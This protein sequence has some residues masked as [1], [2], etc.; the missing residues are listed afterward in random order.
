[1]EDVPDKKRRLRR[2]A[3]TAAQRALDL[4]E[5]QADPGAAD[6]A[7][8]A[9]LMATLRRNPDDPAGAETLSRRA[10]SLT[11]DL[12]GGDEALD[13][14]RLH[15][16]WGLAQALR[17]RGCHHEAA[18]RLHAALMLACRARGVDDAETTAIEEELRDLY[19]Y[20]GRF[21]EADEVAPPTPERGAPSPSLETAKSASIEGAGN[22]VKPS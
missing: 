16:L 11:E 4:L 10:L 17:R 3:E 20:M 5:A 9:A 8:V 22:A 18:E 1:M 6:L 21:E 2:E 13:G 14:L 15:S 12:P 7:G 19:R